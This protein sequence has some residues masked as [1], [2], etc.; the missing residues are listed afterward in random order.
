MPIIRS[1]KQRTT[2]YGVQYCDEVKTVRFCVVV[3]TFAV[4]GIQVHVNQGGVRLACVWIFTSVELDAKWIGF[5]LRGGLC[6]CYGLCYGVHLM[7]K[8]IYNL[9]VC[10]NAGS[11]GRCYWG[12]LTVQVGG[13]K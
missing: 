13:S 11:W 2:A 3:M 1:T 9:R 8:I 12:T 7:A 5:L 6:A 10:V 4:L